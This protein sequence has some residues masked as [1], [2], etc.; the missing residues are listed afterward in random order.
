MV[1][2]FGI[3]VGYCLCYWLFCLASKN[4]LF[5]RCISSL[6]LNKF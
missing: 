3:V 6:F 4:I 2:C 5:L 1:V